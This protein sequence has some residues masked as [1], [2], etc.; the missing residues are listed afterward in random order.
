M[1]TSQIAENGSW[2]FYFAVR[3]LTLLAGTIKE[4]KLP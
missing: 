2:F 1:R 4:S 3:D